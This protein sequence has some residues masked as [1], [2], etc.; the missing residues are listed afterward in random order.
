MSCFGGFWG[1]LS[2]GASPV[3]AALDISTYVVLRVL[4]ELNVEPVA[5]WKGCV[6]SIG[7]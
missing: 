1:R 6:F 7:V 5:C 4:V 3:S 2:H